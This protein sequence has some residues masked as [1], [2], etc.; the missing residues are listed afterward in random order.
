MNPHDRL[1]SADFKSAASAN[2]AIRARHFPSPSY[3]TRIGVRPVRGL[4]LTEGG[5]LYGVA[6][7]VAA[8]AFA[9]CHDG[10]VQAFAQI[11]GKLVDFVLSVDGDG[12]ACGIE[13]HLAVLALAD[14]GLN[15]REEA[16]VCLTVEEVV[17]FGEELGA[18]HLLSPPFF[19]RK[20]RARRSRNW[21]RAR[22]N[23]D[24]TAGTLKPSASA[25]SSVERFCTSRS[26]NTVRNPGG[27]A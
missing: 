17:Q 19:W 18:G 15:L 21:R 12:L 10:G 1:R 13:D 2:F 3:P 14:V 7:S 25:V 20:Y 23:L 27:R 4:P 5:E 11:F 6:A 16:S 26:V 24:L 9:L 8:A 22:S